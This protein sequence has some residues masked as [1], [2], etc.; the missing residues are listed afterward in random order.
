MSPAYYENRF[1]WNGVF[2]ADILGFFLGV[3]ARIVLPV[4][5]IGLTARYS[6]RHLLKT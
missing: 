3:V 5:I 2:I 4:I 6:P 1:G